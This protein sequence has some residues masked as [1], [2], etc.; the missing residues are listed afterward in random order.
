MEQKSIH[1]MRLSRLRIDAFRALE[2]WV[3]LQMNINV[4][5]G[6]LACHDYSYD[7]SELKENTMQMV[8]DWLSVLG[9]EKASFLPVR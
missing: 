1:G 5:V 9:S 3:K 6:R 4:L 8:I 7:P 2:N